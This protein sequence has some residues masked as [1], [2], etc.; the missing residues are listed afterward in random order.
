VVVVTFLKTS[1]VFALMNNREPRF[2]IRGCLLWAK[3]DFSQ[4]LSP[5]MALM[6]LLMGL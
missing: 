5:S 6:A 1:I 4:L 3:A 2:W